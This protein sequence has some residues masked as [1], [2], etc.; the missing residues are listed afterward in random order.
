[1]PGSCL[2]RFSTMPFL[3]CSLTQTCDYAS[4]GDNSYWLSST[5]PMLKTMEP[6]PSADLKKYVSRCSV[7]ESTTRAIAIH[8]QSVTI[9]SCPGGWEE[10]WVG[11]SFLMH[12]DAGSGGGGQSLISPGSCLQDF[13][14]TPFIQCHGVGS[15][16][17]YS[18]ASS[19]W[20]ATLDDRDQWRK[21]RPQTLKANDL[22]TRISR[23]AV[24]LRRKSEPGRLVRPV[25]EASRPVYEQRAR[26]NYNVNRPS[27]DPNL[28]Q[29]GYNPNLNRGGYDPNLNRA[30]YNPNLNRGGYDQSRGSYDPN[31]Y[32]GY[33][34][35][36]TIYD[37]L[38]ART[39]NVNRPEGYYYPGN[40][41][42][43]GQTLRS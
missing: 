25:V 11:F 27:Y 9:P 36:R 43:Q 14:P 16:N 10:L 39:Y 22:K 4:R 34:Q 13:R 3:F 26:P 41:T 8:S 17:Y 30:G 20:L 33:G 29:A 1:S 6:I 15:C 24:C 40:S 37:P 21:P 31:Q 28:N 38:R 5:E 32:R 2:P 18:T 35:N 7:C 42:R 23:C 19:F 12:T